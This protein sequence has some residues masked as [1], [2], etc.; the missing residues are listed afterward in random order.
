MSSKQAL[1]VCLIIIFFACVIY[2]GLHKP[3]PAAHGPTT[4]TAGGTLPSGPATLGARTQ[5]G[6]CQVRGPLP[7]PACTPG[8]VFPAAT[9][10]VICKSGYASS[11]RNV[12]S[13]TK[14]RVYNEYGIAVHPP[15]AYEVDHLVSLQ[16]GGSNEIANLWPEAADPTPGFHEK[17]VVENYLHSQVC[18]GKMTLADAQNKIASDWLAVYKVIPK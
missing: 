18:S 8:A 13:A 17:D 12:S 4:P 3:S 5:T 16:L 15:G 9:S 10:A 1:G 2:T 14:T 11:V 6:N 7:D